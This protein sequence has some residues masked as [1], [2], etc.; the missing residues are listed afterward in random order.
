MVVKMGSDI[1][2]YV[3][4]GT[5]VELESGTVIKIGENTVVSLEKLLQNK[6]NDVS[7]TSMKVVTGKVWANVKKLTNTKSEFDFETPTAVASIRGTRLGVSVDIQG[8]AVDVYEGLVLVREK[9]TGKT[10]T[11]ATNGSA[12]VHAGVQGHRSG[13]FQ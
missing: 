6:K 7:N 9:S 5:D 11:V 13:G 10:V 8:T 2:T 12:I 3:E 4:S 1:R